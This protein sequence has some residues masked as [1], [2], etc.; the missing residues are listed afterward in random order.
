VLSATST[1]D[2]KRSEDARARLDVLSEMPDRWGRSV[3]AWAKSAAPR[4]QIV[5]GD[6]V[7][8]STEQLALYQALIGIDPFAEGSPG[9]YEFRAEEFARKAARERKVHTSWTDPDEKY[10]DA[11]VA[12]VRTGPPGPKIRAFAE[13]LG[14]AGATNSLSQLL[15]KL[16][17]PG[18]PDLYQGTERWWFALVDPD[19]RRPA[20]FDAARRALTGLA[21]CSPEELLETWH[22]GRIKLHVTRASLELRRADPELFEDRS[23]VALGTTGELADHVVAFSRRS[24]RRWAVTITPRLVAK[25]A[26]SFATGRRWGDTAVALPPRAPVSWRDVLTGSILE[27]ADGSLLLTDVFSRLPVSLLVPAT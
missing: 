14:I 11:L 15:W 4:K 12:F 21:E 6:P 9:P 3:R 7:P 22:D 5:D 20:D 13:G 10:E 8:D 17:A 24:K 1:H 18:I 16:T 27:A 23:Y 26:G 25:Q 2:S 19:N